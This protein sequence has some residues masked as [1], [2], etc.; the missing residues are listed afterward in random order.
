MHPDIIFDSYS[1]EAT[2]R[3]GA[4]LGTHLLPREIVTLDGDLGAGKTAMTRGIARGLHAVSRVSSP[5]FTI[6]N[7]YSDENGKEVLFH[8]DTYRL[9]NGDDFLD[10]GLDEY[11]YRDGASV[12]EWGNVIEDVL[13]EDHIRITIEGSGEQRRIALTL[14]A[15][16]KTVTGDF[17]DFISGDAQLSTVNAL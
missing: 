11:F 15:R 3:F 6:V 14:N 8:F 9:Q 16:L 13:P 4:F 10:A 17:L 7:E 12:I 5:T 1:P 2:E